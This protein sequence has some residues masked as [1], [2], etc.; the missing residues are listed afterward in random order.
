LLSY[1]YSSK[2]KDKLEPDFV[3]Q[4]LALD[5]NEFCK[6]ADIRLNRLLSKNKIRE[7]DIDEQ[8]REYWTIEC[9]VDEMFLQVAGTKEILKHNEKSLTIFKYYNQAFRLLN[10]IPIVESSP[11]FIINISD[12]TPRIMIELKTVKKDTYNYIIKQVTG[13]VFENIDSKKYHL[14]IARKLK[15]RLDA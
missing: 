4:I 15:V 14:S 12:L 8:Y 1:D 10:W 7:L 11:E 13:R 2:Q 9:L 5:D 6:L 3:K